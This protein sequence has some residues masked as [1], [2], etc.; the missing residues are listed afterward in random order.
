MEHK[1]KLHLG[2]YLAL[3]DFA[4]Q[5]IKLPFYAGLME[6]TSLFEA[7]GLIY[8][9]EQQDTIIRSTIVNYDFLNVYLCVMH[10]FYLFVF[11]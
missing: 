9:S 2:S 6:I 10:F 11:F 5:K 3:F 7:L 4:A 1:I 8:G